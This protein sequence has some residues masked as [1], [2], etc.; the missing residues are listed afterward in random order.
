[1]LASAGFDG[2]IRLWDVLSHRQLGRPLAPHAGWVTR[3]AFSPDGR[4]LASAGIDKRVR[5]WDVPSHTLLGDPLAGHSGDVDGVA[6]SPDG[7]TLVSAS[8]DKSVRLWDVGTRR[9]LGQPVIGRTPRRSRAS[10]SAPTGARSQPP[11]STGPCGSGTC[12]ASGDSA[13]P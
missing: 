12:A 7:R 11:R 6:F 5:L 4:T 1:M 13:T 3:V 2:T 9:Q 10:P 8:A